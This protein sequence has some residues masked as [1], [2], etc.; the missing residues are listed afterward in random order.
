MFNW[1]K[2]FKNICVF[3]VLIISFPLSAL[4]KE[5]I[6]NNTTDQ[7]DANFGGVF[8]GVCETVIGNG[9]CT[10]RAAIQEAND[11]SEKDTITLPEGEII[12]IGNSGDDNNL[13]GDLDIVEDLLLRGVSGR[14]TII[15]SSGSD[16][17]IHMGN[18]SSV[19]I[20]DLSIRDGRLQ[21][22]NGAGIFNA[23][24]SLTIKNCMILNNI[25]QSIS[26]SNGGGIFHRGGPGP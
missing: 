15:K 8:D 11:T 19:E 12:L 22:D 2:N 16:R 1:L 18:S 26:F 25:N 23:G 7:A 6:V 20:Y 9:A 21:D 3:S 24:G 4:A 5:F 10:L 13:G 14:K 17:V